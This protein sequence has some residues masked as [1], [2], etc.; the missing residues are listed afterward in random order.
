MFQNFSAMFKKSL[1]PLILVLFLTSCTSKKNLIYYQNIDSYKLNANKYE[2]VLQPDDLLTIVVRGETPESVAPFNMPN[3]SYNTSGENGLEVQRMF[4]YL[5]D[6]EGNIN[7]PSIGK[8]KVGSKTRLEA[9]NLLIEKLSLYV[10]NPKVDVRILNFKISVQGEV[11]K[12]GTFSITSERITLLEAISLAGDLTIYGKRDN[13]LVIREV[14]GEKSIQR[15]DL[16]KADFMNSPYYYLRQNDVVY[17]EPNKTKINSAVV[18]PN[19]G[20]V[21][22]AVSLLVTILALTIK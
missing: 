15:I 16:K 10:T 6:S 8:L 21:L 14:N 12:P 22:S 13:I 5:I 18:G 19:I 20:I 7:F 9:E 1:I 11:N 4:T 2:S 3:I 17:I